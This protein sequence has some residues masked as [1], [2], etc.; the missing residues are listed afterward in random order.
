MTTETLPQRRGKA[1]EFWEK[2][3]EIA[4]NKPHEIIFITTYNHPTLAYR[5]R[6][7]INKGINQIFHEPGEWFATIVKNDKPHLGVRSGKITYSF[8]LYLVYRPNS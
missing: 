8:N 1:K 5:A 6:R 7:D 3:R 4:I 2:V